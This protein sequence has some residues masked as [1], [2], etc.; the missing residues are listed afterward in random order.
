MRSSTWRG[1][2]AALSALLLFFVAAC[3][4]DGDDATD[5]VED[6]DDGGGDDAPGPT[7]DGDDDATDSNGDGDGEGAFGLGGDFCAQVSEADRFFSSFDDD[8]DVQDP[9]EVS[10]M[11]RQ[12]RDALD[13]I[14]PPAEIAADWN[15]L[16]GAVGELADLFER[17]DFSDPQSLANLED[18]P[19]LLEEFMTIEERFEGVEEAGDRVADYV[20][21][22]CGI[23]LD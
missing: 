15:Q 18:D 10:D 7:D 20:R 23:E 9:A 5:V 3:G 12:A 17:V 19:E 1:L 14:D 22:E 16:V 2:L 8:S 6:V 21:E 11:I 4:D 13:A